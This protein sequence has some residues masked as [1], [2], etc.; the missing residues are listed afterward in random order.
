[1]T[2]PNVVLTDSSL[3]PPTPWAHDFRKTRTGIKSPMGLK[4]VEYICFYCELRCVLLTPDG[5]VNWI[6]LPA[7]G[8]ARDMRG[9]ERV[10]P[11]D[12]DAEPE[13]VAETD[14]GPQISFGFGRE[15]YPK[16]YPVKV[17]K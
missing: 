10:D 8:C 12:P 2:P 16:K 14:I 17:I 3:Q 7:I 5:N 1:M 9:S 11:P 6:A 13:D 15:V 4:G